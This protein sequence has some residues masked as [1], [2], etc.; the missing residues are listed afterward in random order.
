MNWVR[1][2]RVVIALWKTFSGVFL[3][4]YDEFDVEFVTRN[5]YKV[6]FK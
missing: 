3:Y 2:K 4:Y 1:E 6:I 5:D